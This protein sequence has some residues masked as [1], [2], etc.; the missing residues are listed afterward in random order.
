MCERNAAASVIGEDGDCCRLLGSNHRRSHQSQSGDRDRLRKGV[1]QI[2]RDHDAK[3][4]R[5]QVVQRDS[6]RPR[7]PVAPDTARHVVEQQ[8]AQGVG[9][10]DDRA[11]QRHVGEPA[12]D[13]ASERD[14]DDVETRRVRKAI[15]AG[16]NRRE[17]VVAGKHL[18]E[19]VGL[20]QCVAYRHVRMQQGEQLRARMPRP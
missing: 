9:R 15:V 11:Q 17:V 14:G 10:A 1:G 4:E 2:P 3:A 7:Q 20:E 6:E 5:D 8:A 18:L 19:P 13:E 16:C 12:P